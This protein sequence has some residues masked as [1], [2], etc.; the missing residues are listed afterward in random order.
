MQKLTRTASSKRQSKRKR[1]MD[2]S[3]HPGLPDVQ[4]SDV[5]NFPIEPKDNVLKEDSLKKAVRPK[6]KSTGNSA[7]K[8]KEHSVDEDSKS[9]SES[10]K[11]EGKKTKGRKKKRKLSGK[12]R[13]KAGNKTE[14]RS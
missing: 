7:E 8:S 5:E 9:D 3:E 13:L 4:S 1:E 11:E 14:E 6:R 10:E 2:E 12:S